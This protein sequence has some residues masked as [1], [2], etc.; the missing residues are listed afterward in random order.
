MRGSSVSRPRCPARQAASAAESLDSRACTCALP[1]LY[2]LFADGL[3]AA[4]AAIPASAVDAR[5]QCHG[6]GLCGGRTVAT[7][8]LLLLGFDPGMRVSRPR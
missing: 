5:G 1:A 7:S 4:A 6:A 3:D 2:R 8:T